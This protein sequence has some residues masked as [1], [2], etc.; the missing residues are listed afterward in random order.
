MQMLIGRKNLQSYTKDQF[1]E[2]FIKLKA[3]GF[4]S[5]Y[6]VFYLVDNKARRPRGS[7]KGIVWVDDPVVIQCATYV[8]GDKAKLFLGVGRKTKSGQLTGPF[9]SLFLRSR[10]RSPF[11]HVWDADD[12]LDVMEILPAANNEADVEEMMAKLESG[13]TL[14]WDDL[15]TVQV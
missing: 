6:E 7:K 15:M 1:V 12:E 8:E 9:E 3:E 11:T 5:K 2:K 4:A 10:G 13:E 14:T